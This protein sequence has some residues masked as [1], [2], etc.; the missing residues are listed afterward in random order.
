MKILEIC[1]IPNSNI[2]YL[3][4]KALKLLYKIYKDVKSRCPDNIKFY[5]RKYNTSKLYKNR[6]G[7][8]LYRMMDIEDYNHLN[9]L[10]PIDQTNFQSSIFEIEKLKDIKEIK[11]DKLFLVNPLKK[12]STKSK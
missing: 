9:K 5:L 3:N 7:Y 1:S 2:F 8:K 6:F 4:R 10:T 11:N 12:S